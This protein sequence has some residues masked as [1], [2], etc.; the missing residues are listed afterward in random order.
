MAALIAERYGGAY[1]T[2]RPPYKLIRIKTLLFSASSA[3]CSAQCLTCVFG[4]RLQRSQTKGSYDQHTPNDL[5]MQIP[6][7]RLSLSENPANAALPDTMVPNATVCTILRTHLKTYNVRQRNS[8]FL[9]IRSN[10][11]KDNMA[12]SRPIASARLAFASNGAPQ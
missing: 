3:V 8:F 4:R 10:P 11:C 5:F 6:K 2:H 7:W 12:P 1:D 9:A